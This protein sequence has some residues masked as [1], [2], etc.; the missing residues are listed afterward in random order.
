MDLQRLA[1]AA[2]RVRDSGTD[3]KWVE[4]RAILEHDAGIVSTPAEGHP[5]KL[6]I[7]TEHRDTLDYLT[8]RIGMLLGKPAAVQAIHGGVDRAERRRITE[9]FTRN[10]DCQVLLATDAAGEGLNLQVAHLMVNYDLPWN[11]NRIEQRFGRIHRIGQTEVCQLW[12]LVAS[13]TREGEVFTRLLDKIEEQRAA[14]GGKVFDVLGKAFDEQ[15]LRD[16]LIDAIQYGDQ[17]EVRARMHQVIDASISDGLAELLDER[18]L[19]HDRLGEHDLAAL[20]LQMDEARVRRLQPHYIE[21]A[22]RT[23]LK[24]LGGRIV[25]RE[26]GRF[27][28]THVPAAVPGAANGPVATRYERVTFDLG[29][30]LQPSGTPAELLAPGQPLHDA[31][32]DLVIAICRGSL[33]HG[34]VLVSSELIEPHLLLG[35]LQEV[36]DGTETPVARKFGYAFVASN[37]SVHPAGPAPHLDCVAAPAG[38]VVD[39]ARALPW[40]SDAE[41]KAISYIIT[42]EL[43]SYV[44]EVRPRRIAELART[45]AEVSARL[46]AEMN[47][48]AADAEVAAQHEAASRQT[49]DSAESLGRRAEELRVRLNA[50]LTEL[51]R[52]AHLSTK[53]PRVVSAALV[54]PVSWVDGDGL[55]RS[56]QGPT[57][58]GQAVQRRGVEAVLA[59]ERA[60]GRIPSQESSNPW[61][62]VLSHDAGGDPI[63]IQT[64]CRILGG[65]EVHVSH[66]QVLAGMNA[67]PGYRLALVNVHPDGPHLDEVR[68]LDQPFA[69]LDLGDVNIAAVRLDWSKVW[70]KGKP[71]F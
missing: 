55:S 37:G 28:I 14:Y 19:A 65:D 51:D 9:E 63:R 62:D 71:P 33:D 5:R 48:L 60:L 18:A 29:E 30:T 57:G 56:V 53:P 58:Q 54:L 7:F 1:A 49:R 2:E 61:F 59:A 25:R 17:P 32:T 45:R 39:R 4:L 64:K 21:G 67:A 10:P 6:I 34:T 47:R 15:P 13:T 8:R 52:Q 43:A 26:R 46:T 42:E 11:P 50:R 69:T 24:R 70:P 20:R 16:L 40:L 38:P 68:Y 44:E 3:K 66:N 41:Q 31:V 22:F 35:I 12:N 27:E 23:G 36:V